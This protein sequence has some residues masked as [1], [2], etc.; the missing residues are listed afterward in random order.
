MYNIDSIK[1]KLSSQLNPHSL[2]IIDESYL[3]TSHY[4]N[5]D[6]S[7]PSHLYIYCESAAFKSLSRIQ[8]HQLIY[9]ILKDELSAGLHALR[10]KTISK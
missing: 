9:N 6:S 4:D 2:K 8:C 10:I 5:S 1:D 3:H 7:N